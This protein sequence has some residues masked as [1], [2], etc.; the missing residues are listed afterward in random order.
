M[1]EQLEIKGSIKRIYELE[2]IFTSGFKH[3]TV[4]GSA[5]SK[6]FTRIQEIYPDGSNPFQPTVWL[7]FTYCLHDGTAQMKVSRRDVGR[8]LKV[9]AER[10]IKLN[11]LSE[12]SDDEEG[13]QVWQPDPVLG[14]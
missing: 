6:T 9:I 10:N 5:D 2:Q 1:E 12:G 11:S 4:K 8:F 14:S 13:S 7:R 3:I